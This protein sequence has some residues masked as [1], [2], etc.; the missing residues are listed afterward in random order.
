[1]ARHPRRPTCAT[2][3]R[4]CESAQVS[5]F[6]P[7]FRPDI[8]LAPRSPPGALFPEQT[9]VS[10]RWT[11]GGESVRAPVARASTTHAC[12]TKFESSFRYHGNAGPASI[13]RPALRQLP[14]GG[15]AHDRGFRLAHLPIRRT[16]RTMF[17][18]PPS[19]EAPESTELTMQ[20]TRRRP[21]RFCRAM[22]RRR[23]GLIARAGRVEFVR[24]RRA[25]CPTRCRPDPRP[26]LIRRACSSARRRSNFRNCADGVRRPWLA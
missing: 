20:R 18:G 9:P 7:D 23:H 11:S 19:A 25:R 15:M 2:L 8:L 22:E 24:N 21:E 17:R 26:R 3:R 4:L 10:G 5:S 16:I 6:P 14:P 1:M 12:S 13:C